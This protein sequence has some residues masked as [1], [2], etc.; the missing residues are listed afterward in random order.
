MITI[1]DVAREARVSIATVSHVINNTRYVSDELSKRVHLAMKKLGYHPNGIARSLKK[2]RTYTIGMIMPDNSNPFFAEVALGI[3]MKSFD[4]SY[5]VIFCNTNSD[6]QKES[7]YLD[8]LLKKRVDG[9]VFV[10]SG[11]NI[12][13]I[14]FIKS[15]KIPIIVVDREIKGLEVDSVLVDNLSGGYQA[16]KH[17]LNLGH[18]IISCI[19]GP[20][21]ITPSSERIEGYKKALM[22]ASLEIDEKLILMGDFQ[23]EGGYKSAKKLLRMKRTPTAIFACNDLMAIGAICAIKEEGLSVPKDI[24]VVGFDDIALASFFNPKLTTVIQP[25]YIMGK[26]AANMLIERIRNK[27][28]APRRKLLKTEL[29]IR[30]STSRKV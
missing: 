18:K 21:L 4:L 16:T 14:K 24:S 17:L 5:N 2:K 8:L 6:V 3:E 20:S 9:I 12:N 27:E 29:I 11:S 13:S 28:M 10:S 30:E 25:K 1:R 15:Q 26:L 7:T 23:F 19:S 22:E